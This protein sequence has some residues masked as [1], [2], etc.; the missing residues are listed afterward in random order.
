MR[1]CESAGVGGGGCRGAFGFLESWA[2]FERV[3]LANSSCRP[4]ME[5]ATTAEACGRAR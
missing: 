3:E 5:S 2:R 1:S 4:R